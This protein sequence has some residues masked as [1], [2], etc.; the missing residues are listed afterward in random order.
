VA[1]KKTKKPT[2]AAKAAPKKPKAKAAVKPARTKAAAEPK[3]KAPAK[4]VGLAEI[5]PLAQRITAIESALEA[6]LRKLDRSPERGRTV[7]APKVNTEVLS[8]RADMYEIADSLSRSPETSGIVPVLL[9]G[10]DRAKLDRATEEVGDLLDGTE[11]ELLDLYRD[12]RDPWIR[13]SFA[14]FTMAV[15]GE[16]ARQL[17]SRLVRNAETHGTQ[18]SGTHLLV[19]NKGTDAA[20]IG[21]VLVVGWGDGKARMRIAVLLAHKDAVAIAESPSLLTDA[22]SFLKQPAGTR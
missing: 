5:A 10:Q 17:Y 14:K 9:Y 2:K 19:P 16:Q 21:D 8:L 3:A 13:T 7:D 20:L 11:I 22:K 1:A 15:T 4:P 18:E 12:Q 6:V